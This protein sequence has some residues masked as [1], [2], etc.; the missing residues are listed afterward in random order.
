MPFAIYRE[1]ADLLEGDDSTA[2]ILDLGSSFNE[3]GW[4]NTSSCFMFLNV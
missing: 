2:K 1:E 4:V 3:N